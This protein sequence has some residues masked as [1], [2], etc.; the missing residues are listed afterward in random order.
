MSERLVLVSD[1]HLGLGAAGTQYGPRFVDEFD[2]D[3]ALPAFLEWLRSND[4]R[5]SHLVMLGDTLD[6]LRVPVP[7]ALYARNDGEAVEQLEQIAAAHPKVFEALSAIMNDG[8]MI[9]FVVGNHDV[10]LARPALQRKLRTLLGAPEHSG[11]DAVGVR[12]HLWGDYVPG[13]LYA[14]HGM[15][16]ADVNSFRRPLTR[17]MP[18]G[19]SDRWLRGSTPS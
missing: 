15:T 9:D 4:R 12:F 2:G 8:T 13:L 10:E 3:E 19:P 17:S 1:I 14:E 11:P 5:P 6:F 18:S 16:T 7:S